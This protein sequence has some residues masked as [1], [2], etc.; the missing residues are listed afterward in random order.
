MKDI[1]EDLSDNPIEYITNI[2]IKNLTVSGQTNL[3]NQRRQGTSI[4]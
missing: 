2:Y 4:Q 3:F 1:C